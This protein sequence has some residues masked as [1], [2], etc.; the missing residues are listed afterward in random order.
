MSLKNVYLRIALRPAA[1]DPRVL[2]A[3]IQTVRGMCSDEVP[4][5]VIDAELGR[6]L[7]LLEGRASS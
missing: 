7:D 1:P 6:L 2:Y 3:R 5:E 4:H